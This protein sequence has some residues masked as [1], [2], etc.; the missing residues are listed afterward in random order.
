MPLA[1]LSKLPDSSLLVGE[2]ISSIP[3]LPKL[4]P[5]QATQPVPNTQGATLTPNS[6]VLL[7]HM[8]GLRQLVK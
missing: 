2:N 1:L 4:W 5:C 3:G 8:G 7:P 6:V